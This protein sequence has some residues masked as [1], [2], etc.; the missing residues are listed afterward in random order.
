[1]K[2]KEQKRAGLYIRV[3][4]TNQ[5]TDAQQSELVAYAQKRGWDHRVYEDTQSGA[6]E[7]RPGLEA[8]LS[9]ARRRKID[10][11]VVWSLDRLARSLK[12]LLN[13]MVE[14]Q[15]LNVDFVCLKQDLDTSTPA[16]RLT[17]HVL[18]AVAE[19]ERELLRVRVQAGMEEAK[20][21]GRRIGR[22]PLRQFTE[23]EV[24]RIRTA[25]QVEGASLRGLAAQF[26]TTQQMVGRILQGQIA[27]SKKVNVLGGQDRNEANLDEQGS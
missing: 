24:S 15:R 8:L 21:Q 23:T 1:M 16:G 4:T 20:R 5:Q 9:D 27:P 11:V 10:V 22:P 17:Y 6:K 14:F 19:F 25:R 3:S 12:H 2:Q 26:G 7:N 13:L 18:G